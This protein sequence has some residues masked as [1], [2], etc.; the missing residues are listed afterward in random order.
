MR[1]FAIPKD[2]FK[3]LGKNSKEPSFHKIRK[4]AEHDAHIAHPHLGDITFDMIYEK[5]DKQYQ[6]FKQEEIDLE[7]EVLTVNWK[8]HCLLKAALKLKKTVIIISDMYHSQKTLESILELRGITGYKKLFVS[9]EYGVTKHGGALFDVA[10]K[11]LNI[12]KTKMIHIGDN[13]HSDYDVPMSKGI[14]SIHYISVY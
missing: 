2:L 3:K 1:P 12:D 4:A 14:K 10:I 5:M 11:E 9:S 6:H 13:K 7:T 8:T